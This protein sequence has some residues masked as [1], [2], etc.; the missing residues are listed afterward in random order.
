MAAYKSKQRLCACP[1][2]EVRLLLTLGLC[3]KI[4]LKQMSDAFDNKC[5]MLSLIQ[6]NIHLNPDGPANHTG[7]SIGA[8][9]KI[10]TK[11]PQG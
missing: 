2:S 3:D 1:P 5:Q 7:S 9:Y 8:S 6:M 10:T 4:E 11:K